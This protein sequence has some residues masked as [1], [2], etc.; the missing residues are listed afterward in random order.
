MNRRARRVSLGL[1][2]LD[3]FMLEATASCRAQGRYS[4]LN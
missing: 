1:A 2:V 3:L 4:A